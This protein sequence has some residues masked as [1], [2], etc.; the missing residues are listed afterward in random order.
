MAT[1]SSILAWKIPW[2]V[3]PDGL[4]SPW[5]HRVRH[6]C[7]QSLRGELCAIGG[8]KVTGAKGVKE[9]RDQRFYWWM[10]KSL[11][12]GDKTVDKSETMS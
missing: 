7:I 11:T 5:G 10:L 8:E 3:K 2:T 4:Q 1:H 12:N 6:G 9:L